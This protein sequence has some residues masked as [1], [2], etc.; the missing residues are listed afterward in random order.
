MTQQQIKDDPSILSNNNV[1]TLDALL[2][3]LNL[4][5][6]D[7]YIPDNYKGTMRESTVEVKYYYMKKAKVI[8]QYKDKLTDEPIHPDT[9]I[10]GHEND[11]YKTTPEDID[12]Y[13]LTEDPDYTPNNT[14]GEMTP[15]TI[16]VTYYYEQKAEVEV[17]HI[18]IVDDTLIESS[19]IQGHVKDL[20][21]TEALDNSRH[22]NYRL[23]TN[24]EYYDYAVEKDITILTDNG[25]TTVGELLAKLKLSEYDPYIPTNSKGEMTKEKIIVNYYYKKQ[26]K[27][28]V[29]HID[30]ETGKE[31]INP[32]EE[33]KDLGD[34][35][36]TE[37]KTIEKYEV[38]KDKLPENAEGIV[39]EDGEEVIYYYRKVKKPIIP[40]AN[41]GDTDEKQNKGEKVM[42]PQTGDTTLIVALGMLLAFIV[43]NVLQKTNLNKKGTKPTSVIK[44]Q[45]NKKDL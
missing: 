39:D 38:D 31:L 15:D 26:A 34:P 8:V 22:P 13:D 42:S 3:K 5:P 4:E 37:P 43:M 20:Y 44:Q 12:D 23:V 25:V 36:S 18:Y 40:T 29:K 30:E 32:E 9:P 10:D 7:P 17:N 35:Y 2:Q 41:S 27:I 24:K 33:T 28:I 16:T 14:E 1:D 11:P 21:K 6:N 19:N 45:S